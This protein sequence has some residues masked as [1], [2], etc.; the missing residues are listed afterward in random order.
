M[1]LHHDNQCSFLMQLDIFNK[2]SSEVTGGAHI[3]SPTSR[4]YFRSAVLES[5]TPV[6]ELGFS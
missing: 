3:A 6:L 5:G 4:A 1:N 2:A